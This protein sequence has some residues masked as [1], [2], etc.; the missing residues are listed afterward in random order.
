MDNGVGEGVPNSLLS[1]ANKLRRLQG[2]SAPG[3]KGNRAFSSYILGGGEGK[4]ARLWKHF[5]VGGLR[6]PHMRLCYWMLLFMSALSNLGQKS[7]AVVGLMVWV[8]GAIAPAVAQT[9]P[10][11]PEVTPGERGE[12]SPP[13]N[14]PQ[15]YNFEAP[16]AAPTPSPNPTAPRSRSTP[17]ETL[18]RVEVPNGSS[19]LLIV[20]RAVEP[21]AFIRRGEGKIQVGLFAERSNA[22]TLVQQLAGQGIW[23]RIIPL[24]S[25][26]GDGRSTRS[27][28]SNGNVATPS[29]STE[30]VPDF[31]NPGQNEWGYQ[32]V[33][34]NQIARDNLVSAGGGYLVIVPVS[35]E[36]LDET[37][38]AIIESGVPESVVQQR[39]SSQTPHLA[40]GPFSNRNDA[41]HWTGHLGLLGLSGR[42]YYGK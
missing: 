11:P 36:N 20:V 23:A 35:S 37:H 22:E 8:C 32:L 7:I 34:R 15:E 16:E 42:I 6:S 18:Y 13:P 26:N 21:R 12:L 14:E 3:Q 19:H 17:E 30:P 33:T 41:R 39:P 24:G 27:P 31:P 25:N 40:I 28:L 29:L 1:Q 38:R 2:S 9:L 4:V 5:A 10:P